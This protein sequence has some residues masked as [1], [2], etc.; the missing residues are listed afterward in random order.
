MMSWMESKLANLGY[1]IILKSGRE[2]EKLRKSMSQQGV[3][4]YR[5]KAMRIASVE[6]VELGN[7]MDLSVTGHVLSSGQD[8]Q[9]S[10]GERH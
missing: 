5:E 9:T 6:Q 1:L 8:S 3:D 4:G 10:Q 2:E 7:T